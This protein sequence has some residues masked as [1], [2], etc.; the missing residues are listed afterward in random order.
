MSFVLVFSQDSS[1]VAR[2]KE[3]NL[4]S[5][6]DRTDSSRGSGLKKITNNWLNR[7]I[8]IHLDE[9]ALRAEI[10]EVVAI[11]MKSVQGEIEKLK[12]NIEP[13]EIELKDF[14][15]D[16]EPIRVDIPRIQVDAE[17]IEIDIPDLDIPEIDL[18]CHSYSSKD[19]DETNNAD[20]T[21]FDTDEGDNETVDQKH[22]RTNDSDSIIVK[23][24]SRQMYESKKK[25]KS[26]RVK[27][28]GLKKLN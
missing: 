5:G 11:A 26:E 19:V 24:K 20:D 10:E 14:N 8:E 4:Q 21:D 15:F 22:F 16:L 25:N 3:K 17:P 1:D 6:V 12:I 18:D 23:D 2:K 27:A 13:I 28:K 9:Q 7:K